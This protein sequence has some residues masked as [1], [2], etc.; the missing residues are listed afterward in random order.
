MATRKS[1][2]SPDPPLPPPGVAPVLPGEGGV[3]GGVVRSVL[4]VAPDRKAVRHKQRFVQRLS[5]RR[6]L[7]SVAVAVTHRRPDRI[8]RTF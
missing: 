2:S 5:A 7:R 4:G 6:Y 3:E 1:L 8:R